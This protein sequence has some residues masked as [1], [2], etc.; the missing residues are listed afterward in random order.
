MT[1]AFA[2][3]TWVR[4]EHL[5]VQGKLPDD[6]TAAEFAE[7]VIAA[8][9]L[10]RGAAWARRNHRS[11]QAHSESPVLAH[12]HYG[13]PLELIILVPPALAT[14]IVA[15]TKA[16]NY[17]AGAVRS[18]AEAT[19]AMSEARKLDAETDL[20][21]AQIRAAERA[22]ADAEGQRLVRGVTQSQLLGAGVEPSAAALVGTSRAA[23][24][25]PPEDRGEVTRLVAGVSSLAKFGLSTHVQKD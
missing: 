20:I 12:A 2:T 6:L 4:G 24:A 17:L 22:L 13:S 16:V 19:R 7:I 9:D 15:L 21:R 14:T 11:L 25:G 8:N 3:N 10:Y 23:S 5:V 1:T 18:N